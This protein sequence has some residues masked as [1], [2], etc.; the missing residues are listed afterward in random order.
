M[1][2]AWYVSFIELRSGRGVKPSD[3]LKQFAYLGPEQEFLA[4][5]AQHA[6]PEPWGFDRS[7][8]D[9]SVLWNYIAY[10]FYRLDYEGKVYID[11]HGEFAGLQHRPA[12]PP[13]RR[14][15]AGLL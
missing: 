12:Q 13:L 15:P 5:L 1:P 2:P 14:G 6:E 7:S 3:K 10:T 4:S 8:Q 11:P 9:Y